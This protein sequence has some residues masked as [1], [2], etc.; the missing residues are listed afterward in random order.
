MQ[1]RRP[2]VPL[3]DAASSAASPPALRGPRNVTSPR[4]RPPP[5]P[6]TRP[7]KQGAVACAIFVGFLR[8]R[9]FAHSGGW[10]QHA[11]R[12]RPGVG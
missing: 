9:R 8:P 3:G 6:R 10:V 4:Q 7:S 2:P 1:P 5:R 12:W 11:S